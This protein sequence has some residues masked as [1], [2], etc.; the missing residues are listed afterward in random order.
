MNGSLWCRS[1]LRFVRAF[2]AF[3]TFRSFLFLWIGSFFASLADSAYYVVLAW[4]VLRLSHSAADLGTT[5]LLASLPRLVFMAVGGV[6]IDRFNPKIILLVSLLLRAG[7]LLGV[8]QLAGIGSSTMIL[9]YIV[10]FLFGVIDAFYW[11][12]QNAMVPF[13]VEPLELGRANA[14]IQ[15]SQQFSV[16]VGPLSAG[17]LLRMP[18]FS[19]I[20][21]VI[22][23]LY[24][25]SFA[26][27]AMVRLISS[28]SFEPKKDAGMKG[29]LVNLV[30]GI[31]YVFRIRVLLFLMLASMLINLFFMG[32]A[33]IGLPSFVQDHGWSGTIY[34]DFESALGLGAVLGGIFVGLF[35]GLRGHF[36]W[37]ALAASGIGMG[38]CATSLVHQWFLGIVFMGM[39]GVAISVTDVPIITY[40]QTIVDQAMLGRVMSLLS[41]MS[42]GLTPLSYA[43]SALVLNAH[44][45]QPAQLMFVGGM[46]VTIF[47]AALIFQRDFRLME[48]HPRWKQQIKSAEPSL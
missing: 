24:I 43:L 46:I 26:V 12:T 21:M 9:L 14:M 42:V 47:C 8:S 30:E 17:L 5:L 10:A 28:R 3:H 19:V 6:I 11:P 39:S 31:R 44:L 37:L 15:T 18:H 22:A 45:L 32:P 48:Q 40:V 16:V 1:F 2:R 7:I 4:F 23:S 36:R 13:V 25:M 38:L 29:L 27:I 20:F 34:G 35:N 33:N 41:L